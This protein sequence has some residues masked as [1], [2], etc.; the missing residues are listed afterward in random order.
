MELLPFSMRLVRELS[1]RVRQSAVQLSV[2]GTA[3]AGLLLHQWSVEADAAQV[4]A[5][6]QAPC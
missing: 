5:R 1:T 6:P 3:G 4:R 2:L